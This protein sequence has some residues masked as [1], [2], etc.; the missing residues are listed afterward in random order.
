M[1]KSYKRILKNQMN[2]NRK[3]YTLALKIRDSF[4]LWIEAQPVYIGCNFPEPPMQK[5]C[6][7]LLKKAGIVF[8]RMKIGG[9]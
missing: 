3:K 2:N 4:S 5:I 1:Q 9:T 7:I 8:K 6:M